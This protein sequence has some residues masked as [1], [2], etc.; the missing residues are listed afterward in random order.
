MGYN[1]NMSAARI[2]FY[3]GYKQREIPRLLILDS[4]EYTIHIKSRERRLDQAAGF[5]FDFFICQA[6][7]YSLNVIVYANGEY[8]IEELKPE[9]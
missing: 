7:P 9:G 8:K 1:K 6:G 2:I 3:E 5:T 4:N